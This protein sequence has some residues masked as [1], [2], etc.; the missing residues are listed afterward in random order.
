MA[1]TSTHTYVELV[2]SMETYH[3]VY[4]KLEEAGYGHAFHRRG[5]VILIDMDG[6]ALRPP[7]S[8]AEEK[9]NR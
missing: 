8:L 2:V 3:E 5:E 4:R 7:P 6:I 9:R 1:H